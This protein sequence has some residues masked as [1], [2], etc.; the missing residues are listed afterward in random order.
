MHRKIYSYIIAGV[1]DAKSSAYNIYLT[2]LVRGVLFLSLHT[3]PKLEA[4]SRCLRSECQ[5]S[6]LPCGLR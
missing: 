4:V 3:L 1:F 6:L 2:V 5:V